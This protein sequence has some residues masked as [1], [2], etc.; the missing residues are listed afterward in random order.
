MAT[1]LSDRSIYNVHVDTYGFHQSRKEIR[2]A[3]SSLA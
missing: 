1:G 2:R 3:A